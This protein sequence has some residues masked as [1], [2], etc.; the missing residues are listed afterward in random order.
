MEE[1]VSWKGQSFT[2]LVFT[3]LVFLCSIFFVLGMLVGRGQGLRAA[4]TAVQNEEKKSASAPLITNPPEQNK[5]SIA[6]FQGVETGKPKSSIPNQDPLPDPPA[7]K[8]PAR[9]EPEI[10]AAPE[11]P[12][13]KPIISEKMFFIQVAAL[14]KE[15][16]ARVEQEKLQKQGFAT[17]ISS[18]GGPNKLFHVQVGPFSNASDAESAKRKLEGLGYKTLTKK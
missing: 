3:G 7:A 11:K 13:L 14:E 10:V 16:A 12:A 6:S 18:G 9:P 15:T 4:K 17:L 5:P 2:L 1:Q 8:P